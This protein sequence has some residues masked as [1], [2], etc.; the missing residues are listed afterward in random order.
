MHLTQATPEDFSPTIAELIWSEDPALMALEF[1]TL[2]NWTRVLAREWPEV[3]TSNCHETATL[4]IADGTI[5]GHMNAFHS[6]EI[7]AR[8]GASEALHTPNLP[9]TTLAAIDDL[10]AVPAPNAFFILDIAV[11]PSQQG[12]G[13]GRQ[14][15]AQAITQARAANC[16]SVCLDVYVGNPALAFYQH[17]GF[18]LKATSAPNE[19]QHHGVAPYHHMSLAL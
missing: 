2:E 18:A 19:L 1:Q 13:L 15:I 16:T 12:T 4:A 14:F 9:D 6:D 8:F 10:F 3:G 17:L 11:A 7:P 5:V